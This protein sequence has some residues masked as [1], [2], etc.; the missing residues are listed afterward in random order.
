M[1]SGPIWVKAYGTAFE[2]NTILGI[3]VFGQMGTMCLATVLAIGILRPGYSRLT[4]TFVII[5]VVANLLV[6][7]AFGSRAA[8]IGVAT[9]TYIMFPF[10]KG[11]N[12]SGPIVLLGVYM[13][14]IIAA[15]VADLR[16]YLDLRTSFVETILNAM[17]SLINPFALTDVYIGGHRFQLPA[18]AGG[19]LVGNVFLLFGVVGLLSEGVFHFLYGESFLW[20]IVNTL[21]VG[22]NPYRMRDIAWYFA[23][24]DLPS[25]GGYFETVKAA[26]QKTFERLC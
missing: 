19:P 8:V 23:D 7:I 9:A 4:R 18:I 6:T 20:M 24:H 16:V 22:I 5:F 25:A 21:P 15:T 13:F 11:R 3:N 17:T 10:L 2:A 26:D 14:S 1:S 12:L